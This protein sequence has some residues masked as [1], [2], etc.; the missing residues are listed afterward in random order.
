MAVRKLH[1]SWQYDFTL[2]GFGRQRQGG[3]GTRAEALL[4]EKRAREDLLSGARKILFREGYAQYMAATRMKD[5]ARDA[6]EH[7]WK[8]IEPELGPLYIEGVDTSV[9]DALKRT[10]PKHLGPKT[11]NQHLILI[12][13]VLRFLWKRSLLKGVPYVPMEP[14]ETKHVDWYTET[15]RDQLLEGLFRLEPQWY[16]FYYLTTRLG[17]RTGEVYAIMHR[18]VRREPPQLV[19]DQ[20]VQRGTKTRDAQLVPRKNSE[21]YVLDLTSDIMAAV[22]WHVAQGYAGPEFLFTKNGVFARYIDSH[23]RPLTLVQQKLGLRVLSHHKVGRHSVA[24][25]AVTGGGSVK[26]VQA[27]LGHRSEQSTHQYAHLGSGA[28]RQLMEALK[29]ARAPHEAVRSGNATS[30]EV[31]VDTHV[32]LAS[33]GVSNP[34]IPEAHGNVASTDAGGT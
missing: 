29:P 5:R 13:A 25:Q 16:L 21:A 32:N 15:E 10:L 30:T 14:V 4:A 31:S 3:Y 24:S 8:R 12:R 1:Q 17:L 28:Q 34:P 20:A 27:Q 2:S 11:V 9:L 6:Y 26:A 7:V 33:T 22:D 23:K 19:V 18:Q